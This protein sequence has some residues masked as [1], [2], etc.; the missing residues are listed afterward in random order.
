MAPV[1]RSD[2]SSRATRAARK[3]MIELARILGEYQRH[4]VIVGGWVPELLVPEKGHVGSTDVDLALD[5]EALSDP[6]YTTILEHLEARGY[7]QSDKQPFIFE[8]EVHVEG[9]AISVQVDLMSGEYGGTGQSH[10]TQ[11]VQDVRARKARGC[12]LAFQLNEEVELEDE[13]PGGGIDRVEVRV[14]S[15]PAF[16]VMKAMAMEGRVKEKDAWD[17][18]FCLRHYP[19]GPE[20]IAELIA[21]HTEHGLVQEA[22][23]HLDEKFASPGHVGPT[24]VADFDRI[25]GE[26]AREQRKRDAYERVQY[27]LEEVRGGE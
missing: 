16:F 15:L 11:S 12:D 20:V 17:L 1:T 27:V 19:G 7:E 9:E 2:Y 4:I 22:L 26:E 21:P 18:W 14:A 24:H 13:L 6:G 10:R 5:H 25:E 23:S 3:V 8:R